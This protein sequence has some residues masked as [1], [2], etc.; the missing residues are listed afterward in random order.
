MTDYFS[1]DNTDCT[2]NA[3]TIQRIYQMAQS[4]GAQQ[5]IA[6]DDVIDALGFTPMDASAFDELSAADI[7]AALG[8]VPANAA[9]VLTNITSNTITNA[10]GFTPYNASNPA[11]YIT[12]NDISAMITGTDHGSIAGKDYVD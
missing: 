1:D 12:A 6:Y 4:A 8:Y 10:L 2:F 11:G 3:Y 7:S 9:T 5:N